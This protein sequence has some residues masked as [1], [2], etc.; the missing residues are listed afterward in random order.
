LGEQANVHSA[1]ASTAGGPAGADGAAG[2]ANGSDGIDNSV[3]A[4]GLGRAADGDGDLAEAG[5]AADRGID[6]DPAFDVTVANFG[7]G[8][9]SEG[10]AAGATASATVDDNDLAAA[11]DGARLGRSAS[12]REGDGLAA[13][14][15]ASAG[16]GFGRSA[17]ARDGR[18]LAAGAGGAD[19]AAGAGGADLAAG[20]GGADLAAGA[21]GADLAAGAGGGDRAAGA[22]R[23][24][25]AADAGGGADQAA[26][27]SAEAAGPKSKHAVPFPGRKA[28]GAGISTGDGSQPASDEQLAA[29]AGIVSD[30]GETAP[31]VAS[32][33][34]IRPAA[35]GHSARPLHTK[36]RLTIV[37][38]QPVTANAGQGEAAAVRVDRLS[39][40][41]AL[42][43]KAS[44]GVK[45]SPA[46]PHGA[47]P[48]ALSKQSKDGRGRTAGTMVALLVVLGAAAY[49]YLRPR[50][51]HAKS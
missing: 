25:L 49:F 40:A 50:H 35:L 31:A 6:A 32:Y 7:G 18:Q 10:N 20:A 12:A 9:A 19:L 46:S 3:V 34:G 22:R 41:Y 37:A 28:G 23:T 33:P 30:E 26:G 15:S 21:G 2:A 17:S 4:S 16:A 44:G 36:G 38:R 51:R 45:A 29:S 42:V 27:N 43:G 8:A 13:G 14:D 48:T 39:V 1:A 47:R 5:E 11:G 24:Q